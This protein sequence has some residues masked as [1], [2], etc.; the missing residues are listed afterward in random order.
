MA[1]D[2]NFLDVNLI[3]KLP[4]SDVNSQTGCVQIRFIDNNY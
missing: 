3:V 1:S 4:Q 2:D